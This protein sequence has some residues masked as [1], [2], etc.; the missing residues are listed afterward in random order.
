[1]HEAMVR[2]G[3]HGHGGGIEIYDLCSAGQYRLKLFEPG[4]ARERGF[5]LISK[6]VKFL[7]A[8]LVLMLFLLSSFL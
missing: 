7:A 1:M 3:K 6:S 5:D 8:R 2:F 4:N